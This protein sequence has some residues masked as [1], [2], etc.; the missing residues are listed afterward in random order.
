MDLFTVFECPYPKQRV[1]NEFDGGYII[2]SLPG[3]YDILLSGGISN[4][5][6]FEMDMLSLF[7]TLECHAFD[8]TIQPLPYID[9]RFH[10]HKKN[11]GNLSSDTTTNLLEYLENKHN[12]FLKIDIEGFEYQCID[13]LFKADCM[14]TL[15]QIVLEIHTP[16]EVQKNTWYF[17][18]I[19]KTLKQSDL[20]TLLSQLNETHTLI[21]VHGN[22]GCDSFLEESIRCPNVIECTYIRNDMI[23]NRKKNTC[24]FPI[25]LDRPNLPEKPQYDLSYPP[26]CFDK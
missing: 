1:G 4:D 10:F 13:T 23:P 26:F 25:D 21:H 11:I 16:A 5:I 3:S 14:K 18:D 2:A 9:S 12:A 20:Y 7:P 24:P 6:S 8:G 17:P 15:K 22:N 19:L